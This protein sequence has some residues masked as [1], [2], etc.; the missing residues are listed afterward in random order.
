MN[1]LAKKITLFYIYK[2]K[3]E[4]KDY[5][6][7]VYCFEMLISNILNFIIILLGALITKKYFETL[8][9]SLVFVFLRRGLGGYHSKTHLGCIF[10]LIIM[11]VTM[12]IFVNY[13]SELIDK[14]AIRLMILCLIP[15]SL[16]SPIEH[17]FN[18][19]TQTKKDNLN[20]FATLYSCLLCII[21]LVLII[22]KNKYFASIYVPF[23]FSTASMIFGKIMYKNASYDK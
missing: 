23:L 17:P 15:I 22:Y 13:K 21:S 2:G 20:M 10:L 8:I 16:L 12:I 7:Y 14:I 9:F 11:Y 3:I 6:T 4:K 1:S 5:E 19:I 18:P